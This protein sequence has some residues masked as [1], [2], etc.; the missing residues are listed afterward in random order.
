MNPNIIFIYKT[1]LKHNGHFRIAKEGVY[2]I[3]PPLPNYS[4]QCCYAVPLDSNFIEP[5]IMR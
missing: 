5:Y 3:Y 2:I 4:L 1:I